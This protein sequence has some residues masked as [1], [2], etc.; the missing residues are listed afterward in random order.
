MRDFLNGM[1]GPQLTMT[2]VTQRLKALK[3]EEHYDY[4]REELQA[5]CLAIYKNE[6]AAL[7]TMLHHLYI[8]EAGW[9]IRRDC[10][11]KTSTATFVL[12]K[13]QLSLALEKER[14]SSASLWHRRQ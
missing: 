11:D 3:E 8:L 2:D 1:P 5:G 13:A 9:N 10:I 4:P 6:K 12:E 14:G 7:R